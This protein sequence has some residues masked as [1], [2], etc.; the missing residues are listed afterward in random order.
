MTPEKKEQRRLERLENKR[1]ER[2]ELDR[3]FDEMMKRRFNKP[4]VKPPIDSALRRNIHYNGW[5]KVPA[6]GQV[7]RSNE[8]R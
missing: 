2:M 3:Q 6:T 1:I 4:P 8:G 5:S 7:F